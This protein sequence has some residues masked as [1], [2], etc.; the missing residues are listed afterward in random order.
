[1]TIVSTFLEITS[2]EYSIVDI[3]QKTSSSVS[4]SNSNYSN[5]SQSSNS[6]HKQPNVDETSVAKTTA[7]KAS[8]SI[9]TQTP[10]KKLR[11]TI[12]I[13]NTQDSGI[14]LKLGMIII[15]FLCGRISFINY[16]KKLFFTGHSLK[17]LSISWEK[18]TD[19]A[20]KA[21]G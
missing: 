12:E 13:P 19:L 5:N 20:E 2:D 4:S 21:Y 15:K 17:Y 14:Q 3:N 16:K 10:K 7:L 18:N 11:D 1:M 8:A 9:T 6:S